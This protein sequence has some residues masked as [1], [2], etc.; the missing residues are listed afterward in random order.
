VTST[1]LLT[2]EE[3]AAAQSAFEEAMASYKPDPLNPSLPPVPPNPAKQTKTAFS[4][5]RVGD[6]VTVT[7]TTDVLAAASF[8]AIRVTVLPPPPAIAT[9]EPPVPEAPPAP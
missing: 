1:T 8:E 7:A 4:E 6:H 2:P 5:L 9:P 3:F